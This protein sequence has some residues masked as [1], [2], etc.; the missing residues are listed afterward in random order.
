MFD[1][2]FMI[3]KFRGD[4]LEEGIDID[5]EETRLTLLQVAKDPSVPQ[6]NL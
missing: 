6:P 4:A 5:K 1:P 3:E 2:S